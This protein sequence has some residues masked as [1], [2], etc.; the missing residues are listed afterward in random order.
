[1]FFRRKTGACG[2]ADRIWQ[3]LT[4]LAPADIKNN[5]INFVCSSKRVWSIS[6]ESEESPCQFMTMIDRSREARKL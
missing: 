3:T 4:I 6:S 2:F 5:G 1:V